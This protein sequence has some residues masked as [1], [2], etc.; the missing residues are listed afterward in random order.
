MSLKFQICNG[1]DAREKSIRTFRAYTRYIITNTHTYT[2][3]GGADRARLPLEVNLTVH[4][5]D[6]RSLQ[7][8]SAFTLPDGG[9]VW[10]MLRVANL[11]RQ[12]N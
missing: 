5:F 4:E 3:N 7:M 10:K 12:K 9:V 2:H 8:A 11:G 1:K 6:G